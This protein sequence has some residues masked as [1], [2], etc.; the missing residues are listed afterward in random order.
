M[1]SSSDY[2]TSTVMCRDCTLHAA[3]RSQEF[4][5]FG[6]FFCYLIDCLGPAVRCPP[7]SCRAADGRAPAPVV[8]TPPRCVPCNK[9]REARRAR[10][11]VLPS[12]PAPGSIAN[13]AGSSRGLPRPRRPDPAQ[14]P[15]DRRS[16][17]AARVQSN[18]YSL[19]RP[20]GSSVNS[21]R[22]LVVSFCL[23]WGFFCVFLWFFLFRFGFFFF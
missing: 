20:A 7:Q 3:R 2:C 18:Q 1:G 9:Q 5:C 8:P 11:S 10:Q 23:V 15:A 17:R 22:E 12:L 19:E 14:D 21:G 4:N 6:C 16:A 13:E